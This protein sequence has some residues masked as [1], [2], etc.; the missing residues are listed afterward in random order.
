MLQSPAC[1][2]GESPAQGS[3]C[4]VCILVRSIREKVRCQHE[5]AG[6]FSVW[7]WMLQIWIS[8]PK[9][10][11]SVSPR[12]LLSH[13]KKMWLKEIF[14]FLAVSFQAVPSNT[15]QEESKVSNLAWGAQKL[16]DKNVI[17]QAIN[18][19]CHVPHS[20][21]RAEQPQNTLLPYNQQEIT[22]TIHNP[23]DVNRVKT[24]GKNIHTLHFFPSIPARNKEQSKNRGLRHPPSLAP[25]FWEQEGHPHSRHQAPHGHCK[26]FLLSLLPQGV[27]L[28]HTAS[29]CTQLIT[30]KAW[31]H[32]AGDFSTTPTEFEW[33]SKYF[34]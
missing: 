8:I 18:C 23:A 15:Q 11:L 31:S 33:L 24:R 32:G 20:S 12:A 5:A 7:C 27:K 4:L 30:T 19:P 21:S 3:A 10:G 14:T 2:L 26:P 34:S 17:L 22:Y 28:L 29:S 6:G 1:M 9:Q 13:S 16:R 25:L